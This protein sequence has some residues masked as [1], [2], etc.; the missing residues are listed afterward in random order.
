MLSN[1]TSLDINLSLAVRELSNIQIN[2]KASF[3]FVGKHIWCLQKASEQQTN[4]LP[5]FCTEVQYPEV[6]ST[7]S[8]GD[9]IPN[10]ANPNRIDVSALSGYKEWVMSE[11]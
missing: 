11:Q 4:I 3:F 9:K 2:K 6:L 10:N 5:F 8:P 7:E 1:Y